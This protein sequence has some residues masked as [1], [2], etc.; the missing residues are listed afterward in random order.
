[1]NHFPCVRIEISQYKK[2]T[3][4]YQFVIGCPKKQQTETFTQIRLKITINNGF[5]H[6]L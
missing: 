2:F 3:I 1:M 6:H 4:S 5:G